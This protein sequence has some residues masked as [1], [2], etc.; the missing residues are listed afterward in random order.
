M[1]LYEPRKHL[2]AAE[3][4][5]AVRKYTK[6]T[7]E[8]LVSNHIFRAQDVMNSPPSRS[9]S[10][11]ETTGEEAPGRDLGKRRREVKLQPI[12]PAVWKTQ[13]SVF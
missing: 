8:W 11:L 2:L 12:S 10:N 4:L 13:I 7:D 5:E 9:S 3:E 1:K 6:K